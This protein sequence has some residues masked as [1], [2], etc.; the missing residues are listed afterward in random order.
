MPRGSTS[1]AAGEVGT[2]SV[3]GLVSVAVMDLLEEGRAKHP[4]R[5]RTRMQREDG[6]D[7]RRRV[8]TRADDSA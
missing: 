6:R 5:H 2:E 4:V 7:G 8:S 3:L 1:G